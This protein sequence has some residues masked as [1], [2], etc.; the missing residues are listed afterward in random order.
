MKRMALFLS[1]LGAAALLGAQEQPGGGRAG[2]AETVILSGT[3]ALEQG[4]I[5]L[6]S[7]EDGYFVA[8]IRPLVGFVEGL[9][10]GAAVTVEGTA[11]PARR[12]GGYRL[13]H[14]QKLSLGG[15]E[16]ELPWF[17][18]PGF[19]TAGGGNP[20]RDDRRDG[21]PDRNGGPGWDGGPGRCGHPGWNGHPGRMHG[22]FRERGPEW[23]RGG[24]HGPPVRPGTRRQAPFSGL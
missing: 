16:Y 9:K 17:S 18:R 21:R 13:L 24:R 6:K 23:Y 3:L 11:L 4:R 12:N 14:V 1:I 2:A 7:G 22:R 10:E 15:K 19:R 20:G 5:V 8:G